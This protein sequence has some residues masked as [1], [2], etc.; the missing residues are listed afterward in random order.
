MR[1]DRTTWRWT[2]TTV[3]LAVGSPTLAA[4]QPAPESEKLN[5]LIVLAD[6]IGLEQLSVY[7]DQN[8]YP[9]SDA[10]PYP[11][12]PVI[13]SLAAGG[14]RFNQARA[15]PNCSPTR[16]AL[17]CGKYGFR[18]GVGTVI[19]GPTQTGEPLT[20]EF[21]EFAVAPR[22]PEVSLAQLVQNHDDEYT[23]GMF[24]KLHLQVDDTD[25]H[26]VNGCG[27]GDDYARLVLEYDEFRGVRRNLNQAPYPP[28]STGH[29]EEYWWIVNGV[30][31]PPNMPV[32]KYN[33]THQREELVEWI[34]G[35]DG[36]PFLAVWNLCDPHGPINWPPTS[37]QHFGALPDTPIQKNTHLRAKIEALDTELGEAIHALVD[38]G[39][40]DDT[41]I[42]FLGDNGTASV[43]VDPTGSYRYT[44]DH[45]NHR[46][47]DETTPFSIDPYEED[48]MKGTAYESG[49]RVPL[50]VSG[51]VLAPWMPAHATTDVLVDVV[52]V[53]ETIN[54]LMLAQ[55]GS[56]YNPPP[57]DG[58]S[59]A[60]TFTGPGSPSMRSFSHSAFFSPNGLDP[61]SD[62]D[63]I[64]EY[65]WSYTM[66]I[67]G[68]L[69]K[70][71]QEDDGT[72]FVEEFYNLSQDPL[73]NDS[74]KL[75]PTHKHIG[76][77]R[78]ALV[79]LFQSTL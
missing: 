45:P 4:G 22:D 62:V 70:L 56:S 10:Y 64:D 58:V 30:L 68:Q 33:T 34:E 18:T 9:S 27:T 12:T 28:N 44:E 60:Y 73:D 75:S 76:T 52:D 3:L 24:G 14:L 2:I 38:L 49:I 29:F 57:T 72:G 54:D 21:L 66:E 47:G 25:C 41:V 48:R 11:H 46:T 17:Q 61:L 55:G 59:F 23:T 74:T 77:V 53:Y 13:N 43:H 5:F 7:H 71:V 39:E 50:I 79:S 67:E 36:D 37:I 19:D 32:T 78:A 20:D 15:N 35:L 31:D 42:F 51:P 8:H 16:A 69:Y 40:I 26:P 6:D 1:I 65:R 63:S